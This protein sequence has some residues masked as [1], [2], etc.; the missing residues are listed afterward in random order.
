MICF[1]LD[2]ELVWRLF[3]PVWKFSWFFHMEM[4]Q[5]LNCRNLLIKFMSRLILQFLPFSCFVALFK[6]GF[7]IL[8]SWSLFFI[9]MKWI[10][11]QK[12]F[13]ECPQLTLLWIAFLV[14]PSVN[15]RIINI[16]SMQMHFILLNSF[17]STPFQVEKVTVAASRTGMTVKEITGRQLAEGS[18]PESSVPEHLGLGHRT[19][20]KHT[21]YRNC[22]TSS[23]SG[24]PPNELP[25]KNLLVLH[26]KLLLPI[27]QMA[28]TESM[29]R[30]LR[31]LVGWERWTSLPYM[32]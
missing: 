23:S 14:F 15:I 19:T 18:V 11:L 12:K 3:S 4:N 5:I 1:C 25:T 29:S 21:V 22:R 16:R 32:M 30:E 13:Q 6:I 2:Y 20:M 27:L 8:L 28:G 9:S 31:R 26:L 7:C 10:I 24:I 17:F